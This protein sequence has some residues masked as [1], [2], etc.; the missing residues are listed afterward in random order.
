MLHFRGGC[1]ERVESNPQRRI[2]AGVG[3]SRG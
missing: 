1:I 3:A 2:P